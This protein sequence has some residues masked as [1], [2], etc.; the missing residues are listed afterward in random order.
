MPNYLTE[1]ISAVYI[2]HSNLIVCF[3]DINVKSSLSIY[4]NIIFKTNSTMIQIKWFCINEHEINKG[5]FH[6]RVTSR[7][8]EDIQVDAHRYVDS[9]CI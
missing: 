5:D 4:V 1:C 3:P 2:D 6:N 9:S 7:L 8:Y